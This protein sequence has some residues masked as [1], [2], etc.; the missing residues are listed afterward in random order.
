MT[1]NKCECC[2]CLARRGLSHEESDWIK[3]EDLL[4]PENL[5]VLIFDRC[6]MPHMIESPEGYDICVG[7]LKNGVWHNSID[8]G[9]IDYIVWN[10]KKP[11]SYKVTHWRALPIP[12]AP[13]I[14]RKPAELY[15]T[16]PDPIPLEKWNDNFSWPSQTGLRHLVLN[17]PYIGLDKAITKNGK[18][19][20]IDEIKFF[21]WVKNN[22]DYK[23]KL[24]EM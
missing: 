8:S 7:Y 2:Y 14:C 18:K 3:V 23:K 12:P 4:P 11:R 21:E 19:V 1:E 10:D 17:S 5:Y 20:L 16:K 6:M 9:E 22:P 15:A 24:N 13:F